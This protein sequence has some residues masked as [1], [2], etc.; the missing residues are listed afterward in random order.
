MPP[1][2][3]GAGSSP[4]TAMSGRF[5]Q[6]V[7]E[8]TTSNKKKLVRGR[9]NGGGVGKGT[10]TWSGVEQEGVCL[11]VRA[12]P[13]NRPR[14]VFLFVRL[15]TDQKWHCSIT[16]LSRIAGPDVGACVGCRTKRRGKRAAWSTQPPY[17][18]MPTHSMWES[19]EAYRHAP[20]LPKE[21][22]MKTAHKAG[23]PQ[24]ERLQKKRGHDQR[25]T[26]CEPN[27]AQ[28]VALPTMCANFQDAPR[29]DE[30]V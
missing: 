18:P 4:S 22:A 7:R 28:P 20:I 29:K 23:A 8:E 30:Q 14:V 19:R 2:E 26:I 12:W 10:S 5:G 27:F 15:H 6:E 24:S 1:I 17:G 16:R 11:C 3:A 9:K 25:Y 21:H 13:K